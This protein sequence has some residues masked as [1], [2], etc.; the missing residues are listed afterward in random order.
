MC[1]EYAHLFILPHCFLYS[2]HSL[3][4]HLWYLFRQQDLQEDLENSEKRHFA[5]MKIQA[6]VKGEFIFF[7]GALFLKSLI[8]G[9]E[10]LFPAF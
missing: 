8:L 5:S 1:H 10:C 3:R 6:Y 4:A 7:I 9:A 2:L